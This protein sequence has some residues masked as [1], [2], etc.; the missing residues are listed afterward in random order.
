MHVLN[1]CTLVAELVQF[2][3]AA[4]RQS[5]V[6]VLVKS[7]TSNKSAGESRAGLTAGVVVSVLAAVVLVTGLIVAALCVR[8]RR[9]QQSTTS[10]GS[11][12]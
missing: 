1:V 8:R 4:E 10:T 9:G 6:D 5:S 7:S 2:D 3:E 12:P 11:L